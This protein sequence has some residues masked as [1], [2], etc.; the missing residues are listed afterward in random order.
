MSSTPWVEKYRPKSL[1]EVSHQEDVVNTLQKTLETANLPHLLF[2]GPPGTGKTSTILAVARDLY[3]PELMKSRVL[4]LNASNERGID[5]VREKVKN[6]AAL[7]VSSKD[8]APGYPCPPYKIIIL[9]E[10][11]SMTTDAQSA[12]R[13]TMETY[14]KVTRFCIICN[15]VSRI[16]DPITS[17]CAKFRY[18]PLSDET[19][20][21][22]LQHI[23]KA[24]GI[25]HEEKV[26]DTLVEISE[27]DM[28]RSITLM[29]SA[30]RLVMSGEVMTS[31]HVLE[32]AG[33]VPKDVVT[34]LLRACKSNSFQDIQNAVEDTV[35]EGFPVDQILQK[36][37]A[38]LMEDD[39]LTDL[40]KAKISVRLAESDCKL[41]E[42]ADESL[43]LLD[44]LS[45]IS[46]TILE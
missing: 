31:K 41:I 32:V 40:H 9:D 42:G 11:D 18:K 17:R 4:E 46:T 8:A 14:T 20:K 26:L 21:S 38:V 30:K 37:Q 22:R 34:N 43:Q 25:E 10:A 2:Y 6:F 19:M 29:Q 45:F 1:Q 24:E 36:V 16:I 15:Y 39:T 23:C 12:L 7:A 28:R 44:I 27:G 13:R 33:V 3:G 35:A 5:V